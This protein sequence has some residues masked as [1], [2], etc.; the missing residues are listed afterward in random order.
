FLRTLPRRLRLLDV[1]RAILRLPRIAFAHH[2]EADFVGK[3]AEELLLAGRNR[4]L[5]ELH[6]ADLHAVAERARHHAEGAG[7]FA[8]AVAAGNDQH[9]GIARCCGDLLVDD[10]LLARH[11][12]VVPL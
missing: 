3:A 9:A 10:F 12:R 4:A 11:A 5:D 8:L 7:A 1:A 6:D 2:V